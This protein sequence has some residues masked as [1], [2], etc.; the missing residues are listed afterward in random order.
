MLRI[1]RLGRMMTI[2]IRIKLMVAVSIAISREWRTVI[3]QGSVVRRHTGPWRPP[4]MII[5]WRDPRRLVTC[6][7]DPVMGYHISTW[8]RGRLLVL[9]VE[10]G[11]RR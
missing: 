10:K 5:S 4:M 3:L 8:G 2:S 6:H 1:S 9:V 7:R 11:H